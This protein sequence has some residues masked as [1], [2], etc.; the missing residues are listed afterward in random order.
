[1]IRLATSKLTILHSLVGSVGIGC[2][3]FSGYVSVMLAYDGRVEGNPF[4]SLM[5]GSSW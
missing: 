3:D 4:G 1:M 5:S 2:G